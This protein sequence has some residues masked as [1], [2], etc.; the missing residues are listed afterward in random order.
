M[1][2]HGVPYTNVFDGQRFILRREQARRFH[3][4]DASMIRHHG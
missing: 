3:N 4:F 2:A 1:N